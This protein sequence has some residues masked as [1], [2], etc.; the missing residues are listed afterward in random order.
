MTHD[1]WLEGDLGLTALDAEDL[2]ERVEYWVAHSLDDLDVSIEFLRYDEYEIEAFW[3]GRGIARFEDVSDF[4]DWMEQLDD[5][6]VEGATVW[7][8]GVAA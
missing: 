1:A 5:M 7:L 3:R 4:D 6:G 8:G 2:R